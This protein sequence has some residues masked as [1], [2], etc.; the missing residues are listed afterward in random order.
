MANESSLEELS[1]PL[2]F[3]VEIGSY[4]KLM[5]AAPQDRD[6]V[7]KKLHGESIAGVSQKV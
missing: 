6:V 7:Y 1:G 5:G 2:Q 3:F 4:T